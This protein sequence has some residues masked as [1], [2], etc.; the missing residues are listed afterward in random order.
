MVLVVEWY[1]AYQVERVDVFYKKNEMLFLKKKLKVLDWIFEKL[2]NFAYSF[3]VISGKM[4]IDM[5]GEK[6]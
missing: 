1:S 3:L 4:L 6:T 5:A 2:G